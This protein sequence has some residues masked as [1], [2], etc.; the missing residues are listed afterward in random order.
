MEVNQ[1]LSVVQQKVA[2]FCA[3]FIGF[4]FS[5]NYTNHAPLKEWLMDSFNTPE[6]PFTKAMFG[7]L[8]TAIFLTHAFMQIPAGHLA[9]KFGP[10]KVLFFAL[11]IVF[12]GN[13]GMSFSNSYDEL[14]LWKFL[15][16]FGTGSSFVSGA[17][18]IYQST[19]TEKLALYQGYYGASVL[20]GSGFVIFAV[21]QIANLFNGWS[22]AFISTAFIAFLAFIVVLFIAPTPFVKQHP[23]SS[24]LKM[25]SNSQL[26]LLGIIQMA[27]F[28]LVIVI[29]SWITEML[30][31][32][33]E[34]SNKL[35]IPFVASLILL[36][37]IFSR[38]LGGKLVLKIGVR[39]LII[40][41]LLLNATACFILSYFSKILVLDIIAILLLGIGC[42][43]PYAGLFNRAAAMFPGRAGAAMGLVNMLGIIF[44]LIGAPLVGK[45]A[46][47]S[48][49]FS[50]A[51]VTLG[52][53]AFV[54]SLI[55]LKI[56]NEY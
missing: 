2:L 15:I 19:S 22:A 31:E 21:P 41:S 54:A 28:G 51:F 18:Y 26:Y 33:F 44:I 10:K 20:L 32:N 16:G 47:F 17:R 34:F 14:L 11:S 27:S 49:S 35:V 42:G 38:P 29:G 1:S 37:G 8:T 52:C 25:L 24:L 5:A 40:F 55:S 9:D 56:N 45:I 6:A 48:G 30:K 13:L 12:L 7:F 3:C 43:L 53:F 23:H 39:K 46:D 4:S 36:L 50:A